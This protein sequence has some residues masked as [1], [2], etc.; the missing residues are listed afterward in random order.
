MVFWRMGKGWRGKERSLLNVQ[1][2]KA[3]LHVHILISLEISE[4]FIKRD[5]S[6]IRTRK[7]FFNEK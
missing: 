1:E 4:R 6:Q 2:L 5:F 3:K 7:V